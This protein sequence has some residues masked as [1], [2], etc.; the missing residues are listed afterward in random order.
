MFVDRVIYLNKVLTVNL[1]CSRS[2]AGV[3]VCLP[4]EQM[5]D[6]FDFGCGVWVPS[7]LPLGSDREWNAAVLGRCST[8]AEDVFLK[9]R[10]HIRLTIYIYICI[11]I[12]IYM[13]V[14]GFTQ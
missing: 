6:G 10:L 3:S 1:V 11:Y 2:A 7:V 12:Y 4:I 5:P 9:V 14:S 8:I 13:V